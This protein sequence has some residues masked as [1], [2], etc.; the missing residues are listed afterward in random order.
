MEVLL[1]E[2]SDVVVQSLPAELFEVNSSYLWVIHANKIP[3]HLGISV[4]TEFYSLKANGK[5]V[6]VAVERL[7]HILEQKSIAVL[8]YR[9]KENG[10][11]IDPREAFSKYEKTIPGKVTCLNPLKDIFGDLSSERIKDL[12]VFL[13]SKNLIEQSLGWQLPADF[14]GIPEYGSE[15]IHRRLEILSNV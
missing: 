8:M 15:E 7:I 12:L 3:P 6:A 4:G 10:L 9:I 2:V 13:E 14:S 5:D 1:R 11:H